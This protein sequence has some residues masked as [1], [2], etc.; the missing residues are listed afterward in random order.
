MSALALTFLGAGCLPAKNDAIAV[1]STSANAE[2][3]IAVEQPANLRDM[4]A[5][6]AEA[7][8]KSE[9]ALKAE[10]EETA[11]KAEAEAN[12]PVPKVWPRP[13]AP[14]GV[15]PSDE[16]SGKIVR[17]STPKGEIVFEVLEK[18]GPL[19]ASN[20]V[21]LARSGYYDGLIFHRVEPRFVI[22]GGDPQGTGMGGPGY[23]IAEDPVSLNYDAGIVAMAKTQA[24]H[25]TG[26][27]FFIMLENNLT[28][29]KEYSIFGRVRSGLDVVRKI[30][31]G[32]VMTKVTVEDAK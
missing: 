2:S 8:A 23:T 21:A 4:A 18:E 14:V 25:S 12:A 24:P 31:V 16:V 22:Q 10:T 1:P 6:K 19:A 28:L 26:S 9:A 20:F 3:A 30:T 11:L 7:D 5:L 15:L 32:D 17:I 29:P 27:Q 13:T